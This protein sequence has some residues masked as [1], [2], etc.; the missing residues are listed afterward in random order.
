MEV[1]SGSTTPEDPHHT[2]GTYDDVTLAQYS[3]GTLSG[4]GYLGYGGGEGSSQGG[5]PF[6][7]GYAGQQASPDR[8]STY[9]QEGLGMPP[10][11]E[12][13]DEE[14]EQEVRTYQRRRGGR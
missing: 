14:E 11:P 13:G 9:R 2:T 8:A 7:G 1:E 3:L 4:Y 12:E 10:V 5:S 6:V